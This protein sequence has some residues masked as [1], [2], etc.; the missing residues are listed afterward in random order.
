[1][2]GGLLPGGVG[3]HTYTPPSH[4]SRFNPL[5]TRAL[6]RKSASVCFTVATGS[7]GLDW[8]VSMT[9]IVAKQEAAGCVSNDAE[10]PRPLCWGEGGACLP[11]PP[12]DSAGLDRQKMLSFAPC[13]TIRTNSIKIPSEEERRNCVMVVGEL[14]LVMILSRGK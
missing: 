5:I 2:L 6:T 10:P 14:N 13:G 12:A 11:S 3:T 7:D 4:T 9:H 8:S 1:M